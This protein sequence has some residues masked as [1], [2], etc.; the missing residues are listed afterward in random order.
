MVQSLPP[1]DDR[2][3]LDQLIETVLRD[4]NKDQVHP[5]NRFIGMFIRKL[6]ISGACDIGDIIDESY[7]VALDMIKRDESR[8]N[9]FP[10]LKVIALR[11]MQDKRKKLTNKSKVISRIHRS[12]DH[13]SEINL[14]TEYNEILDRIGVISEKDR[15]ILTLRAQG[16]TWSFIAHELVS[17]GY[18]TENSSL[19]ERVKK[20][21]NRLFTKLRNRISPGDLDY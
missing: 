14:H 2:Q 10:T 1:S 21:G 7:Q 4:L 18:E 5:L 11:R 9:W 19:V 12:Y 3:R 17:Q 6:N 13:Y 20:Y 15:T 8:E 16:E